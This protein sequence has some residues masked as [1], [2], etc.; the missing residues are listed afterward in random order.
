MGDEK[1]KGSGEEELGKMIR[2]RADCAYDGTD[3]WGWQVQ[4]S[5]PKAKTIQGT[6]EKAINN[7]FRCGL[8]GRGIRIFGSGRTDAGVHASH[9]VFHFDAPS[10]DYAPEKQK[11]GSKRTVDGHTSS[12]KLSAVD[13]L[14]RRLN[15]VLPVSIRIKRLSIAAPSFHARH[16]CV[17]KRY[18]YTMRVLPYSHVGG[19]TCVF[20]NRAILQVRLRRGRESVDSFVSAMREISGIFVGSCRNF[21]A[22]AVMVDGDPRSVRRTLTRCDVV[23]IRQGVSSQGETTETDVGS[24]ACVDVVVECNYFLY[25]M[26]RRIVGTMLEYAHGRVSKKQIEALLRDEKGARRGLVVTA[27]ACGLRMAGVWYDDG[28]GPVGLV[29]G[30]RPGK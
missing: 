11:R 18:V 19:D 15:I 13:R 14:R 16:S 25:R 12:C 10:F 23:P 21:S 22:F 8:T 17:R 24:V 6:I 20:Q 2:Y 1:D 3:F 30:A 27:P 26:V 28:R 29:D 4:P 9:Q 7:S 5:Q